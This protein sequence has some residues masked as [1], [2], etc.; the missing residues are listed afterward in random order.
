MAYKTELIDPVTKDALFE[1]YKDRLLFTRKANIYG[2]CIK[3]LT[4][5]E[6]TKD[7][8]DDN[9]YTMS[10]DIRSHGRLVVVQEPG[11]D[12][13]VKYDPY[14]KTAFLTNVDYYGWVKSIALAVASDVLED[15]HKIYSVHGAAIDIG[16]MGVTI[17]A[18][19]GTG[20]TTHSWGLLRLKNARLISDDWYFVRLYTREPI[21]FGS[22]KNCYVES[23]LGAI[24][25]EYK[26][27]VEKAHFD[28]RGR[29]IVNVR[30]AIGSGGVIPMTTV[31]VGI[32]L[33]RDRSDPNIV[34]K[35]SSSDAIAYMLKNDFCNPH[36]LVRDERKLELRRKFF[37]EYFGRMN[38]Y[39][40]NTS[41][42]PL[43]SQDE[44][45]RILSDEG[46][47][48]AK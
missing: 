45:R 17:L 29:A 20:K 31:K 12:L 48:L 5:V 33:K 11:K 16:G 15:E 9:F 39:L 6:S 42:T 21:V 13:S 8:W 41:G 32:L 22:E 3:L 40:V 24:W 38:V 26:G 18:P 4:E 1:S 37:E 44:I 14:T 35:L 10:E 25:D 47:T 23:N 43:Q 36:Q 19:S 27:L 46:F 2:C 7:L 34:R 28:E 30:W